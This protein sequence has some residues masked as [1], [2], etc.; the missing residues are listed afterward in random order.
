MPHKRK[1]KKRGGSE[2]SLHSLMKDLLA[3]TKKLWTRVND[4]VDRKAKER[5]D[6][7]A[8]II[9]KQ[10]IQ[11]RLTDNALKTKKAAKVATNAAAKAAKAAGPQKSFFS[12]FSRGT[13][14]AP[15]PDSGINP[16]HKIGGSHSK[17]KYTRKIR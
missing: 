3:R 11:Q 5:I 6:K 4:L 9:E 17:R 14:V 1:T 2:E 16:L 15:N 13:K 8:V 10:E 12:R 7:T